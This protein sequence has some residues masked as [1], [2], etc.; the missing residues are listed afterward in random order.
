MAYTY[1][2]VIPSLIPNTTMQKRLLDGVHRT[3]IITPDE[4]FVMHNKS[5]DFLDMDPA[6]G[7]YTLQ[8]LGFSAAPATCA[9]N[10]DFT[11]CTVTDFD[12]TTYTAYGTVKEFFTIPR[13]DV[14]A[15]Q[16]FGV[17]G[18]DHETA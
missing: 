4:G 7:E 15:D 9:A 8:K 3:Y 14:P 6:T 5:R 16:V 10:Y 1:E 18:P 2:D 17:T 11:P 12:G 13:T